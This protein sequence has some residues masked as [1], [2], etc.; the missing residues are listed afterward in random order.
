MEHNSFFHTKEGSLT[1]AFGVIMVAFV[2]IMLGLNIANDVIC[3]IGFGLALCGMLYSPTD[4]YILK[5]LKRC[6]GQK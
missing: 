1:L 5:P 3:L 2:I 4:V 6:W